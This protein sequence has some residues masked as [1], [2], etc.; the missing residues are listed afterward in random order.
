M[1]NHVIKVQ[2]GRIAFGQSSHYSVLQNPYSEE[3]FKS[4]VDRLFYVNKWS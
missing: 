3:S 1:F 4:N 2:T